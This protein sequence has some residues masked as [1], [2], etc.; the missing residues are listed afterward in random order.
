MKEKVENRVTEL[1][2]SIEE[3]KERKA[4]LIKT[5][6]K[7]QTALREIEIATVSRLGAIAELESL[8]KKEDR[9]PKDMAPVEKKLPKP[10]LKAVKMESED[11]RKE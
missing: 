9:S 4:Q 7:I 1:K 2:K 10:E 11:E 8:F 6:D 5:M 3:L